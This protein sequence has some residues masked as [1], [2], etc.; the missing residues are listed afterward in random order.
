MNRNGHMH[1]FVKNF[2]CPVPPEYSTKRVGYK[3]E[4][5]TYL[6]FDSPNVA[7]DSDD[8]QKLFDRLDEIVQGSELSAA[9]GWAISLNWSVACLLLRM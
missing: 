6:C 8:K 5:S 2:P 9:T 7:P 1:L 3:V 4:Q